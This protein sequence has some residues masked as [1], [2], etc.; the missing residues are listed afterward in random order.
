MNEKYKVLITGNL[1]EVAIS[2]LKQEPDLEIDY[3]PDLPMS[4]ILEIIEP[5][6]CII[7]RSET[8]VGKELIDR[9]KN[10][11]V[12]AR[13]AVGVANIDVDY[14]TEKGLLVMNT[15]G[16]NTNSAAELAMGLLLAATRKLTPANDAMKQG[17]WDRHR[18]TGTELMG[19]TIG[20]IGLGNVGHRMA[21]FARGFEMR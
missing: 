1:H 5:Y 2:K 16:K 19:K 11:K 3:R 8:P 7:T 9:A 10:L 17:G 13:A 15:P 12:I 4:E 20:L 14:A 21:R 6:H 18:F